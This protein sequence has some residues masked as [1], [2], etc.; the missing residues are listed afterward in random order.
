MSGREEVLFLYVCSILSRSV[1]SEY[2]KYSRHLFLAT[3]YWPQITPSSPVLGHLVFRLYYYFLSICVFDL[4]SNFVL[5]DLTF[6][7]IIPS[8]HDSSEHDFCY[9]L[10][11]DIYL[12]KATHLVPL[13]FLGPIPDLDSPK[14]ATNLML[15]EH[16][17][18]DVLFLFLQREQDLTLKIEE[19]RGVII[20][21]TL[22]CQSDGN[23]GDWKTSPHLYTL[24]VM[25]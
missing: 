25:K 9:H 24:P 6:N 18:L 5:I 15:K 13:W 2:L 21:W 8:K 19:R 3:Y 16:L 17:T 20:C 22:H 10:M 12:Y 11:T 14:L 4:W 7:L 23:V 1:A